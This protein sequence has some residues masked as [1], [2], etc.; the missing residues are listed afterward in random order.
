M[1][2]NTNQKS[3]ITIIS[4]LSAIIS[5]T[6]LIIFLANGYIPE[7]KDGLI[8]KIIGILSVTSIPKNASVYINDKLTT[9]TD[10]SINLIPNDYQ[11][12]IVKDGYLPW[13]KKITINQEIVYQ[14]DASLFK[15]NPTFTPFNDLNIQYSVTNT[16][17]SKLVFIVPI[18]SLSVK[19][20]IYL[21]ETD[22]VSQ[23]LKR[24][25]P[26]F[27]ASNPFLPSD[28]SVSLDFSPDSKQI[29]IKSA[30]KKTSYLI[31]LTTSLVS[32][33][34]YEFEFTVKDINLAK[35]PK[36][37][38]AK[39]ATN[40]ENIQF[41][42]NENE[43]LYVYN[44]QYFVYDILKDKNHLIGNKNNFNDPF[45]LPNSSNIIYTDLNSI[46]SIEFDGSNENTLYLNQY[47]IKTVMPDYDG[48]RVIIQTKI[49]SI[50][51]FDKLF[52]LGIR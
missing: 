10:D 17:W 38:L 50:D 27:I 33:K 22:Y 24:F 20:G 30:T 21:I 52:Y 51:S 9:T 4:A 11:L 45:W 44:D 49:N 28:K 6:I 8:I 35:I 3:F 41:S 15:T 40:P 39:V 47:P 1:I 46:K 34:P 32:P 12:K 5:T 23:I 42:D 2:K 36:I 31:D 26:Q 25:Q 37:F 43:F 19:A 18:S 16:D 7:Y 13:S 14:A 48:K 29:L